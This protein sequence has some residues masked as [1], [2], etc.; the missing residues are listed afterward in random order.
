MSKAAS[1]ILITPVFRL[2]YPNLVE[3]RAYQENGKPKGDPKFSLEALI[4]PDDLENFKIHDETTD[5][6]VP[7]DIRKIA[8]QVA[9]ETWGSDFNVKAE[10]AGKWP[11]KKGDDEADKKEAKG[12]D[13]D[14][15]RGKYVINAKANEEFPPRLYYRADGKRKQIARGMD[16]DEARAKQLFAAGNYCVAEVTCKAG[17]SPQGKYITFYVNSVLYVKEGE[18][19]G[20][21]SLMDR[22]DGIEG[23]ISDYDPTEGM[24]EETLDDEIP[25]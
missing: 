25:A 1:R 16:S 14:P 18:R 17:E 12:K 9:K 7:A 13:G 8:V 23:G 19:I 2:S 20:G 10:F 4:E 24:A 15:Y 3:P 5:G 21:N 11:I 22:F 6:L